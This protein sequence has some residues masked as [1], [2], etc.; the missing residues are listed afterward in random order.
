MQ[1]TD[2]AMAQPIEA[3][4]IENPARKKMQ[5]KEYDQSQESKA[6]WGL[7]AYIFGVVVTSIVMLAINAGMIFGL[8]S[9]LEATFQNVPLIE[10]MIQYSIYVLPM[11][12][13]YLEWYAWDILVS[14][15][16]RH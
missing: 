1:T 9:V 13:L 6:L 5:E 12:L 3:M 4:T 2:F 14:A 10:P 7:V 11:L 15:R 16:R 8:A